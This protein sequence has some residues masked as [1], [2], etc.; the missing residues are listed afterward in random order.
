MNYLD[1]TIIA[2]LLFY[3]LWGL[4][5]GLLKIILD[6]V[7]YIVAFIAAKFLGPI[8]VNFIQTTSFYT[9][10]QN[11]I[12][13]TLNKLSPGISKTLPDIT[14][15]NNMDTLLIQAPELK[16]IF[17]GFPELLNKVEANIVKLSGMNFL[18]VIT[19][20]VVLVLSVILI[21]I[22]SKIVYSIVISIILSKKEPM[23]LAVTNRILGF[24]F[25]LA[26]AFFI[27]SFSIQVLEAFSITS[28]PV[29]ADA[30]ATS[31][32]G[33][34]LTDIPLIELVSKIV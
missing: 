33:H 6:F 29:L 16:Q 26:V 23:P 1:Y 10:I 7:G 34:Y 4:S 24:T 32:Y 12:L 14:L 2:I 28:S 11:E 30:I 17:N 5:K 18:T 15:P 9:H 31:K 27:L 8:L 19:D 22:V 13:D 20:Y 3:S 25:G 21:F